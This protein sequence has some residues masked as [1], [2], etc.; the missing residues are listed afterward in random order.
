MR[1]ALAIHS[2]SLPEYCL[3]RADQMARPYGHLLPSR[4]RQQ[5]CLATDHLT[6]VLSV[7]GQ[8][9]GRRSPRYKQYEHGSVVVVLLPS[10]WGPLI[11][12]LLE[13]T[14]TR[15]CSAGISCFSWSLSRKNPTQS[16]TNPVVVGLELAHVGCIGWELTIEIEVG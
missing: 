16:C 5:L 2:A 6:C 8:N 3:T 13:N 11:R 7:G 12:F 10:L 15:I 9:F 14:Q 1:S 4:P